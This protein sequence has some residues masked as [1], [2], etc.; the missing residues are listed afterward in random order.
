VEIILKPTKYSSHFKELLLSDKRY[1]IAFGSR[2]SGKTHHIILKLLLLSFRSEYNHILYVNKEFRHIKIQQYAEFKKIASQIG[3]SNYF[4]FYEGDYRIVNNVTGTRFTPIGMDDA[5]KTK[6]ISD[7]TVIWWDEITKGKEDDFLTLNALLRTPLTKTHQFIISFNPV[8][9]S[10]W[11]RSYFFEEKNGYEVKESFRENTYLNHSTYLNNEFIDK[12][13]YYS[14]LLQNA[15]GNTNRLLVDVKGLWGV[16]DIKN[17]FFYA[18][19]RNLHFTDQRYQLH[20]NTQL[21]LSFDFNKTPSTL[22]IGCVS[23]KEIAVIDLIL[24][25]ENTMQGRSPLEAVCNKFKEK[26]LDSGL[27]TRPYLI[28]TGDAS[29]TAG[30]A[31]KVQNE[32]F[33]TKIESILGISKSQRKIRKKNIEHKLSQEICNSLIYNCN[34]MIYKSA[35][36]ALLDMEQAQIENGKLVKDN[37]DNGMHI[38]D[39]VRYYIDC[40][41]NFDKWQD[42]LRYY[43]KI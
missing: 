12:E 29:G 26:Y 31:D 40:V 24:C 7:P 2:G 23:Q 8:S 3:L 38:T 30:G 22:V 35:E 6:G 5:E 27:I 13:M 18:L 4:T 28:V 41:L 25:D 39:A 33:Y 19:R 20:D 11:L 1:I 37:K 16:V 10:H 42:Y 32:N 21:Y 36:L 9:E 43:N 34:F 14:T 17:P 15:H